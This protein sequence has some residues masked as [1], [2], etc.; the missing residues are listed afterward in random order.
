M[1]KTAKIDTFSGWSGGR[2][3]HIAPNCPRFF[4]TA[5]PTRGMVP[6]RNYSTCE[7]IRRQN[8]FWG[9][10]NFGGHSHPPKFLIRQIFS[11]A[12]FYSPMCDLSS[13]F[14]T[15]A[16]KLAEIPIFEVFLISFIFY[17]KKTESKTYR[18]FFLFRCGILIRIF[19][20]SVIK[21]FG[22]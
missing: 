8:I 9:S 1:E 21:N 12:V 13:N 6:R 11:S 5:Q 18:F 4:L 7:K 10:P 22:T 2:A 17:I 3:P 15:I 19:Q 16:Q 20:Q 14:N